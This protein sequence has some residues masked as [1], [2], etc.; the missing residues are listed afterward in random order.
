M[1]TWPGPCTR[2][3]DVHDC[4]PCRIMDV[5]PYQR[6]AMNWLRATTHSV[7]ETD[8]LQHRE[9]LSA[10]PSAMLAALVAAIVVVGILLAVW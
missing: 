2:S 5:M 9:V 7:T 10:V 4:R 3:E 1:P 8:R 6:A